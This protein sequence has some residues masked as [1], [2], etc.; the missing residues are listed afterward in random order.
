MLKIVILC[1]F[2]RLHVILRHQVMYFSVELERGKIQVPQILPG[3]AQ[4]LIKSLQSLL[5][6]Y[7]LYSHF[8]VAYTYIYTATMIQAQNKQ[9]I[10]V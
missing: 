1:D 8:S 2:N 7:W 3:R 9:G 5:N 6:K 10:Q 4:M